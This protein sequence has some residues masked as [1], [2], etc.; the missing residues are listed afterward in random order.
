MNLALLWHL[1]AAREIR[2]HGPRQLISKGSMSYTAL[3]RH[4]RNPRN[5]V[6]VV[7]FIALMPYGVAQCRIGR[8]DAIAFPGAMRLLRQG[9]DV[10]RLCTLSW[11]RRCRLLP[12]YANFAVVQGALPGGSHFSNVPACSIVSGD[13]PGVCRNASVWRVLALGCAAKCD[14]VHSK[15]ST[16]ERA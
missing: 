4:R 15:G 10:R 8:V 2:Q 1:L 9:A 5:T 13:R 16:P 7:L 11:P 6:L 3:W 14:S 12:F